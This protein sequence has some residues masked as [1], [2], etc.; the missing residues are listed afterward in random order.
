MTREH[1]HQ[2]VEAIADEFSP[3]MVRIVWSFESDWAERHCLF[4]RIVLSDQA[5]KDHAD[6]A[7]R[8][9]RELCETLAD[10]DL[11]LYFNYH[12]V[13]ECARMKEP[14]WEMAS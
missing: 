9:E 14:E 3:D 4:F 10:L 1:I 12:S 6:V 2:Q 5:A 11:L 8:L 7:R 13:S